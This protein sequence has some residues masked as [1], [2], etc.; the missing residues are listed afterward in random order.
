MKKETFASRHNSQN[1][2]SINS[3]TSEMNKARTLSCNYVCPVGRAGQT[4][5]P[6]DLYPQI[7]HDPPVAGIIVVI[8]ALKDHIEKVIKSPR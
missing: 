7:F 5:Y 1:D 8:D 3:L 4:V 2:Y 6:S